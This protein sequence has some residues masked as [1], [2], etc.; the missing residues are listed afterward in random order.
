MKVI[1]CEN[2]FYEGIKIITKAWIISICAI[3]Q[4]FSQTISSPIRKSIVII[5]E[6]RPCYTESVIEQIIQNIVLP[7]KVSKFRI[8]F[9]SN[10]KNSNFTTPSKQ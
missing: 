1:I 7:I 4:N 10:I 2:Y 3:Y 5:L 6:I 8:I 9:P